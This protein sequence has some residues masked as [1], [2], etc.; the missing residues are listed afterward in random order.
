MGWKGYESKISLGMIFKKMYCKKCG[1]IL[2]I[3]KFSNR[4][5]KGDSNYSDDVLGYATIWIKKKKKVH[6]IYHCFNCGLESTY[7]EQCVIA[8]KQKLLKKRILNENE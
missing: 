6:Y 8:K 5:K 2:K 4:Y 1:N 3:T 7:E